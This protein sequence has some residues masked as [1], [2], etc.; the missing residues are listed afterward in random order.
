MTLEFPALVK[1]TPN[2]PLLPMLR[3]PRFKEVVGLRRS[4]A[5]F[6]LRV[7]AL[8]VMWPALL[9]IVTVNVE[10]LSR[11]TVAGFAYDADVAPLMAGSFYFHL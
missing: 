4:L 7:A 6:I 1:M 2:W 11:A 3:L 5:A 10:P 9:V 8:L